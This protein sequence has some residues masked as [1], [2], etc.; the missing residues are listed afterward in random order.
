MDLMSPAVERVILHYWYF[1]ACLLSWDL[2]ACLLSWVLAACLLQWDLAVCLVYWDLAAT[3]LHACTF[4]ISAGG[5]AILK[6]SCWDW[7]GR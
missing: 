7:D 2:A 6:R 4:E 1:S 5:G 3:L